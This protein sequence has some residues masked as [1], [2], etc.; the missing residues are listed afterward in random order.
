MPSGPIT[1]QGFDVPPR[2]RQIL[3]TQ[4]HIQQQEKPKWHSSEALLI[5]GVL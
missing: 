3:H 5:P 2:R 1:P 4:L